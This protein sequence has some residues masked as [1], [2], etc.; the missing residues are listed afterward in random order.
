MIPLDT[1]T[2]HQLG[3]RL[4]AYLDGRARL[5]GGRHIYLTHDEIARDL[6]TSPEVVSRLLTQLERLGQ[7]RLLRNKIS[8]LFTV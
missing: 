7:V 3:D 1:V 8:L 4:V 2:F 6:S 5:L